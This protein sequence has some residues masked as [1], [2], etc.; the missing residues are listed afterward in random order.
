MERHRSRAQTER[1]GGAGPVRGLL[2]GK[3]L[4]GRFCSDYSTTHR[5][6]AALPVI[7]I[8]PPPAAAAGEPGRSA[9]ES[10]ASQSPKRS[11]ERWAVSFAD[12]TRGS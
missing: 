7:L 10:L 6:T 4:T 12:S 8:P 9:M 2:G 5:V 1:R 3:D 11:S